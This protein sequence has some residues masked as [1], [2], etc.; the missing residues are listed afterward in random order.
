MA[1]EASGLERL[2]NAVQP[3]IEMAKTR[4]I[5][6]VVKIELVCLPGRGAECDRGRRVAIS[7]GL[8]L[9]FV[10]LPFPPLIKSCLKRGVSLSS[11]ILLRRSFPSRNLTCLVG[12]GSISVSEVPVPATKVGS[13]VVVQV[14][15]GGYVG[16]VFS[17][18]RESV[19]S[20]VV[21][22]EPAALT[23]PQPNKK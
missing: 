13:E 3:L 14:S 9:G 15:E 22:A 20:R 12:R 23:N 17:R 6:A 8:G 4:A 18:S 19:V 16:L 11:G 21:I 7:F 1:D 2:G 10:D 5:E